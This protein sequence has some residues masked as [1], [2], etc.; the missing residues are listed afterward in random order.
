MF[1]SLGH[2][3]S[4]PKSSYLAV[5]GVGKNLVFFLRVEEEGLHKEW[6]RVLLEGGAF[7]HAEEQ[8]LFP[9][10]KGRA[11]QDDLTKPNVRLKSGSR[12]GR[13]CSLTATPT[14][15][16]FHEGLWQALCQSWGLAWNLEVQGLY[17][18]L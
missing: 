16:L 2:V 14:P 11:H 18:L 9:V 5:L 7:I 15:L 8:A 6:D 10:A 17:W 4:H 3:A 1:T 12:L 13:A